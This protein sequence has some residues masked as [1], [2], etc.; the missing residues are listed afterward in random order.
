MKNYWLEQIKKECTIYIECPGSPLPKEF[1]KLPEAQS[2]DCS[3]LLI[4][5]SFLE[6][7]ITELRKMNQNLKNESSEHNVLE[8]DFS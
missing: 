1:R 2:V 6:N 4:Q 5:I 3:P 8:I 7:I